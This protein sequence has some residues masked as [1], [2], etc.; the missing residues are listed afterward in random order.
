ML[1]GQ[2]EGTTINLDE[3]EATAQAAGIRAG[4]AVAARDRDV[5]G[6]RS[7]R[8]LCRPRTDFA[9]WLKDAQINRDRNLRLQYLAGRGLNLYQAD[10]IYAD[11]LNYSRAPD[12]IFTGSE[13]LRQ[14]LLQ[15]I[16]T[17]IGH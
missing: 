3:I 11:M 16:R 10:V 13:D 4:R 7:V 8:D 15:K 12:A 2:V 9:P 1:L 17:A 6:R 5:L 14:D